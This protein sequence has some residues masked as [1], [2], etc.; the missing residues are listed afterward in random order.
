MRSAFCCLTQRIEFQTYTLQ[1]KLIPKAL[2]H[3]DDLGIDVWACKSQ[4]FNPKLMKLAIASTLRA[5]VPKHRSCVPK[6]FGAVIDQIVLNRGT[7]HCCGSFGSQCELFS[8]ESIFKGVHL[9]LHNI[10]H[11]TNTTLE[12]RCCLNDRRPN[13]LVT[14]SSSEIG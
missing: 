13:L 12:E 9:F 14:I 1:T 7:H 5:L 8:I 2:T 6:A 10:G 3:Q 11:F 4:G